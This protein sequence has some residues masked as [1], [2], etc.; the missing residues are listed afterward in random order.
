MSVHLNITVDTPLDED[1]KGLLAGLGV[2]VLAIGNRDLAGERFPDVFPGPMTSIAACPREDCGWEGPLIAVPFHE[3]WHIQQGLQEQ[4]PDAPEQTEEQAIT[5]AIAAALE[6]KCNAYEVATG[7]RCISDVG[8]KGRHRFRDV[9]GAAING[10]E[11]A[12]GVN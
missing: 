3:A 7:Y 5:T 2:M 9:M 4:A 10:D 6:G 11:P 8:H 12:R 1:D